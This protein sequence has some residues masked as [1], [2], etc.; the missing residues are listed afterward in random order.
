MAD[1]SGGTYLCR[2][3]VK[4]NR[5]TLAIRIDVPGVDDVLGLNYHR[6]DFIACYFIFGASR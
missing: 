1:R 6:S 3:L 4:T 2:P 5:E